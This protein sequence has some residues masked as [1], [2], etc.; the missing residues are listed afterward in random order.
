G[1]QQVTRDWWDAHGERFAVVASQLVVQEASTGDPE[2]A[3]RRLDVL[4]GVELLPITDEAE[5]LAQEFIQEGVL[6]MSASEDA[7]HLAISV[8]HGVEY[9]LAWNCRHLANAALRL[10]IEELCRS[11]GFRPATICTP[12]ELVHE[13]ED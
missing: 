13:V 8:T 9:L 10:A 2:A 7:L 3:R 11:R 6:P 5:H 1:H 4:A 12:D